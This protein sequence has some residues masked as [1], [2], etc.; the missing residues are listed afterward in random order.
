MIA[1]LARK[2]A[3]AGD[4]SLAG[5]IGDDLAGNDAHPWV[6]AAG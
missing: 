4:L 6:W 3:L 5:V 1:V 2:I